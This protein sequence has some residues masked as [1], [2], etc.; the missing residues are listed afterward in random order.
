M[1][2]K[3]MTYMKITFNKKEQPINLLDEDEESL[4][5]YKFKYTKN[6]DM[7]YQP[8]EHEN[9]ELAIKFVSDEIEDPV[10]KGN[11]K[12]KR[13]WHIIIQLMVKLN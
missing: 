13:K 10:S 6:Y 2:N 12:R 1:K 4:E 7:T 3:S 11:F 5:T 8:F 9:E